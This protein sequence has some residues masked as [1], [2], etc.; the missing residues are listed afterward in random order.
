MSFSNRV[1]ERIRTTAQR[2]QSIGMFLRWVRSC[3]RQ[4]LAIVLL[5]SLLLLQE[6]GVFAQD[7]TAQMSLERAANATELP[8]PTWGAYSPQ[9]YAPCFLANRLQAQ[10]FAFPIV[11]GQRRDV[12]IFKP[13]QA[14]PDR[15]KIERRGMGLSPVQAFT[16]DKIASADAP[17]NRFAKVTTADAF[18]YMTKLGLEFRAAETVQKIV[19]SAD[20][21]ISKWTSGNAQIEYFPINDGKNG[22][23]LIVRVEITNG[24]EQAQ[25][26]FVDVLAGI[27]TPNA[28]FLAKDLLIQTQDDA[29][30]L[31]H[32]R[33]DSVF[34]ITTQPS[35]YPLRFYRVSDAYFAKDKAVPE[36][37]AQKVA[38]PAGKLADLKTPKKKDKKNPEPNPIPTDETQWALARIDEITLAP[39]ASVTLTFCISLAADNENAV[40]LAN[41]LLGLVDDLTLNNKF[42]EGAATLAEN[43]HKKVHYQSGNTALDILMAQSLV[44]VPFVA[45]RRVGIETRELFVSAQ[46]AK[47]GDAAPVQY[48]PLSGAF[49]ALGWA[50]Y[51]PDW[52]AAQ[53]NAHFLTRLNADDPVPI[54]Q[55]I[56]PF[57]IFALWE[58]YQQTHDRPM[59]TRFYPYAKRRYEELLVAGRG[60]DKAT[61]WLFAYPKPTMKLAEIDAN[62]KLCEQKM[63]LYS[64]DYSA[65]VVRAAKIM[66]MMA[67]ATRQ[68]PEETLRFDQDANNAA[69]AMNAA[70]WSAEQGGYTGKSDDGK[71][72]DIGN[73]IA[74]L[75]PL[76]ASEQTPEQDAALLKR[77][78]DTAQYA[79]G[80]GIRSRAKNAPNYQ[81]ELPNGGAVGYAVNYLLWKSLLDR[82]EI[83]FAQEIAEGLIAKYTAS[84]GEWLHGETGVGI[85]EPDTTGD[86]MALLSLHAAYHTIGTG[87]A[88]WDTNLLVTEYAATSDSLRLV[89]RTLSKANTGVI[90][91]VMGKPD[92]AYIT[93]SATEQEFKTDKNGVLIVP[94]GADTTTQQIL[95]KRK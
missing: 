86:T 76:I 83:G 5:F 39:K 11:I 53:L 69:R 57:N 94:V 9:H 16:D 64:P 89:Y 32:A 62:R 49:M 85:G 28:S 15:I 40:L 26:Y 42:R 3:T 20:G 51:R 73:T 21:T 92:T 24:A 45:L 33:R 56:P 93:V 12:L 77:L 79:S 80:F 72:A 30:T 55:T 38:L 50:Q 17:H 1:Q 66:R 27:D 31:K 48:D 18:G 81:P 78:K 25:T 91:C 59:L 8:V 44:N 7:R 34:A 58:L 87:S 43:L 35:V 4:P 63:P 82:G 84:P 47:I 37:D 95:L 13:K 22:D 14:K 60:K 75:L 41:D 74:S 70:L 71:S 61:E 6:T 54:P 2:P 52:A 65:Y 68:K 29:I 10:M 23:G 90:L 36:L 19:A 88:G 46:A 67:E